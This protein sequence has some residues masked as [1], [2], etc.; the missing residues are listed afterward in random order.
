[1]LIE[2]SAKTG[3]DSE[4]SAADPAVNQGQKRGPFC[5]VLDAD[6]IVGKNGS[7]FRENG[8]QSAGN[9]RQNGGPSAAW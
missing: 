2:L 1:M 7:R 4:K 6:R 8:G 3:A 5:A 9:Q